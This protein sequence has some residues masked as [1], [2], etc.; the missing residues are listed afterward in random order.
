M[1]ALCWEK[2]L[3]AH[4]MDFLHLDFPPGSFDAVHVLC[5][6]ALSA[7]ADAAGDPFGGS[8]H[9]PKSAV[10]SACRVP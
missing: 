5:P 4:V 3:E 1:V 9:L 2:G 8:R 6:G 10:S 7:V